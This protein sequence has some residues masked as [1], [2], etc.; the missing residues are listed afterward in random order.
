MSDNPFSLW[1]YLSAI[2]AAVADGDAAVLCGRA[3]AVSL[4]THRHALVNPVL[5]S[6]WIIGVFLLATGTSYTTY[7]GGAAVRALPAR[8]GHRRAGGA[9]LRKPQGRS[10][11]DRAD[12]GGAGDRLDHRHCLGGGAGASGGP[13][14]RDRPVAGVEVRHRRRRDGHQRIPACR[15]VADGG[16][17]GADRHHGRDHR[18]A[19]DE[20]GPG[21]RTSAPAAS[22]S[23]SPPTVSAPRA[24]SRSMRWLACSP[25]SP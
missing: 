7:F 21:S 4:K 9:A 19:D 18:H 23:A 13:A 1:V 10:R 22:Q 5:H 8:A 12:A 3:D 17:S 16:V 2:A 6:I 20:S 14:P 25:A 24:R 15:S 11:G